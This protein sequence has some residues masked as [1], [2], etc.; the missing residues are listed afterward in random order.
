LKYPLLMSRVFRSPWLILPG[1]HETIARGLLAHIADSKL[2]TRNTELSEDGEAE[3][4]GRREVTDYGQTRIIPVHGILGKHL[5]GLELMCGGC[6]LDA[7]ADQIS[8]A[9][10]DSNVARVLFDFRSPGGEV[11]GTPEVGDAIAEL[12][13]PSIGFCDSQCCSGALWLA[14]Q[15]DEFYATRSANIGSVGVYQYFEDWTRALE[16][17][18]VKPN[19]ISSGLYKL[20][21]AYFKPMT[22][23]E[24]AMFQAGCDKIHAEFKEVVSSKR[25]VADEFLQGQVFDGDEAAAHGF[26]AVVD[27]LDT[28]LN[29]IADRR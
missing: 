16:Q 2:E 6:S 1:T 5:S 13:K 23:D 19:P 27:D 4:D 3:D 8:L 20:S 10:E 7:L 17:Q 24:R 15:C 26:L 29:G 25:P 11:T 28:C 21:G 18:G 9:K 14:S 22:D 12:G